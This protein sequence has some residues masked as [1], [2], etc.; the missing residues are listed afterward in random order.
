MKFMF[1]L[2]RPQV[3]ASLEPTACT[4]SVA[5]STPPGRAEEPQWEPWPGKPE[6]LTIWAF[7]KTY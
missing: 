5:T 1:L 2:Q 4:L 7:K 6:G 3:K